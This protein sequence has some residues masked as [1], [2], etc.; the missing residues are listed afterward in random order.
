MVLQSLI[1]APMAAEYIFNG[2]FLHCVGFSFWIPRGPWEDRWQPARRSWN[3]WDC[4]FAGFTVGGYASGSD[5]PWVDLKMAAPGAPKPGVDGRLSLVAI[6]TQELRCTDAC[7]DALV[8]VARRRPAG[9]GPELCRCQHAGYLQG[10]GPGTV[11]PSGR[12]CCIPPR[13]IWLLATTHFGWTAMVK[14]GETAR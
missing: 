2:R 3:A 8:G 1:T 7:N 6:P 4:C 5:A 14:T 12:R 10:C 9:L 11:L 13:G